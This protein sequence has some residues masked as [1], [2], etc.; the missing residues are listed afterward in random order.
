[1]DLE[2][3]LD[4]E[5]LYRHHHQVV[6]ADQENQLGQVVLQVQENQLGQEGP[7]G[8]AVKSQL[9]R[10]DLAGQVGLENRRDQ[11][12]PQDLADQKDRVDR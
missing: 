7:E 12:V 8:Q 4:Q 5:G 2:D 10:E 11:E 9:D 3:L 1:V 6:P